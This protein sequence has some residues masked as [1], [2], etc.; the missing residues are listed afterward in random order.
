MGSRPPKSLVCDP[1][2]GFRWWFV[3]SESNH[4]VLRRIFKRGC[5]HVAA[6]CQLSDVVLAVDPLMGAVSI[7][8]TA[9]KPTLFIDVAKANGCEVLCF[10]ANPDTDKLCWRGPVLTCAS[11]LSYTV[12]LPSLAITPFQLY[13]KL[14]ACGAVKI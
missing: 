9:Q 5:S 14:I 4:P 8:L 13:K 2:K 10:Q 11:Y 6:F 1:R 3:F 12:G 7:T